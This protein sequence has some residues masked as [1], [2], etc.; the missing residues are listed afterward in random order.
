[1]VDTTERTL[2]SGISKWLR[3]M[4]TGADSRSLV[5]RLPLH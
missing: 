3:A 4:R 1:M 5:S 2:M